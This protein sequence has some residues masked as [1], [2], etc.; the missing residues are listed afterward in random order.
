MNGE[1]KIMI[2]HVEIIGNNSQFIILK[3]WKSWD[4][5]KSCGPRTAEQAKDKIRILINLCNLIYI[6]I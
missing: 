4:Q 1:E 2:I 5:K 3:F 6:Y